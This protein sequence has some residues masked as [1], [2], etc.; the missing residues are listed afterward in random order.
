MPDVTI[1]LRLT[2]AAA[3]SLWRDLSALMGAAC[4]AVLQDSQRGVPFGDPKPC[5]KSRA[6]IAHTQHDKCPSYGIPAG[7]PP[8][9]ACHPFTTE[10]PID[11][12]FGPAFDETYRR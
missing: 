3:E 5:G 2:E 8:I 10:A 6:S 9:I 4:S 1:T 11:P 12:A 7:H